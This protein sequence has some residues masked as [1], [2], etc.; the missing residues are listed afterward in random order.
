M[1]K[2]SNGQE[3]SLKAELSEQDQVKFLA[4][5][6]P[7]LVHEAVKTKPNGRYEHDV[8][9]LKKCARAWRQ[10]QL[11]ARVR[12]GG[13][14]G[15]ATDAGKYQEQRQ[16]ELIKDNWAIPPQEEF[17][18]AMGAQ[19]EFIRLNTVHHQ[20]IGKPYSE[21]KDHQ[22]TWHGHFVDDKDNDIDD[23]HKLREKVEDELVNIRV[24]AEVIRLRTEYYELIGE[25][26]SGLEGDL[27]MSAHLFYQKD[28]DEM[29]DAI[30]VEEALRRAKRTR[31]DEEHQ[32]GKTILPDSQVCVNIKELVGALS[33]LHEERLRDRGYMELWL[34]SHAVIW[35]YTEELN[36]GGGIG[37]NITFTRQYSG[38]EG[39][40]KVTFI[41]R[42]KLSGLVDAVMKHGADGNALTAKLTTTFPQTICCCF[43]H[44]RSTTC[45]ELGSAVDGTPYVLCFHHYKT[46]RSSTWIQNGKR[47]RERAEKQSERD[48]NEEMALLELLS[49]D[50]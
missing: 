50:H 30:D 49:S 24:K 38:G 21:L 17:N 23:V 11:A 35:R 22:K 26:Y 5:S 8:D 15:A 31:R 14:K 41:L 4:F 40:R 34:K 47:R 2:R 44:R 25:P 32:D 37:D 7:E 16:R 36:V 42:V 39:I 48:A 46:N 12:V 20:L 3:F 1:F 10:R 9:V 43:S 33:D 6:I 13:N 28:V 27:E 29:Q 45:Q 19:E 18:W